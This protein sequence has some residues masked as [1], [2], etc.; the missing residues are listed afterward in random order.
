MIVLDVLIPVVLIGV[1]LTA[2]IAGSHPRTIAQTVEDQDDEQ[3]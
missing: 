1:I 3:S 2:I